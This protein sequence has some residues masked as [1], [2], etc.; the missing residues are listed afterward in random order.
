MITQNEI[1]KKTENLY[2]EFL[3]SIVTEEAFFPKVIRSDKSVDLD[4]ERQKLAEVIEHSKD[5]KGF[6]YEIVY[7]KTNTRKHGI[8]SSLEEIS[9]QTE[10]DFLKYLHKEKEV[11]EFRENCSLI[12]SKFHELKEW[13]IKCPSKIID[14][15]SQWND[16]L[17]V[18]QY[19][20]DNSKPNLYIRELPIKVH[21]KFI[22]NNKGI[23]KELLDIL[24]KDHIIDNEETN[25][26]KR[27]N[28][29]SP[30]SLVRFRILDK[31]I[32]QKYFSGMNDM[33][34]PVSQFEQLKL[35]LKNVLVV[36][37]KTNLLT[38]A[39]TLSELEETIVVFGSGYKVENL[40]KVEW[41]KQMR[42]FYWGDLDAQGFEILSQFRG[43]FPNVKSLFMD[44]DTFNKF[45]ENDSGTQSKITTELNLTDEERQLYLLLKE[46]NWRLEQE[47][48]RIE[49]VKEF[50]EKSLIN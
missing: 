18:C 21:T 37:N 25:F 9:F 19:F 20:K 31:N 5:R 1:R 22:G 38:I 46:N 28:L 26:E 2:L 13:I 7:K 24:I 43:Y 35:P 6:G 50:L 48:I 3:K 30:P 39:L 17:E 41:L 47:K 29:K 8:Q 11:A 34:V 45:F 36:E 4:K 49:Y 15:H 12:L 42:L 27:F 16:L 40:K 14:N 23:I 33:S 44:N 32:S 10:L